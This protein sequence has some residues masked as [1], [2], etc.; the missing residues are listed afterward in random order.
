MRSAAGLMRGR[1]FSSGGDEV[2]SGACLSLTFPGLLAC[3]NKLLQ[4]ER[5]YLE[6][7]VTSVALKNGNTTLDDLLSHFVGGVHDVLRTAGKT[8]V[9]WEEVIPFPSFLQPLRLFH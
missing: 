7:P 9:V 4:N 1:Y 2:V 6:D 5:C 8:P 3:T